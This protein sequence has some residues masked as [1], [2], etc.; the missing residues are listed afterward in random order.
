M[1]D[2]Q[3]GL[4]RSENTLK[5]GRNAKDTLFDRT[6]EVPREPIPEKILHSKG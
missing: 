2:L 5:I 6:P 4:D 3:F 1:R